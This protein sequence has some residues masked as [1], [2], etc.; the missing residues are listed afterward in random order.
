MSFLGGVNLS[1]VWKFLLSRVVICSILILIQLVAIF[2]LVWGL[3]QTYTNIYIILEFMSV[4]IA[5]YIVNGD[6]NPSYKLSWVLLMLILPLFGSVF[7]LFCGIRHENIRSKRRR[8]KN[9]NRCQQYLS[10]NIHIKEDIKNQSLFVYKN[11]KYVNDFSYY[12]PYKNSFCEYL[13]PGERKFEKL[14]DELQ[15]AKHFI[16]LE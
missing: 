10:E 6:R 2:G 8:Q 1:K 4:V 13:S 11:F 5:V 12:P 16:F 3:G 14:I 7:Y 9:K 15:K